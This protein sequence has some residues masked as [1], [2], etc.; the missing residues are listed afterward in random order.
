MSMGSLY[1]VIC[2]KHPLG[3]AQMAF[4]MKETMKAVEYLH[5]HGGVHVLIFF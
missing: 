3:D 2:E 5:S 1:D 4:V